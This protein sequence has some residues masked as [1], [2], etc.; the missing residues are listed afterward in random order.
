MVEMRPPNRKT[1]RMIQTEV[2]FFFK[3]IFNRI[4]NE[5]NSIY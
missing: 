4:G 5:V 2:G 3:L 1:K